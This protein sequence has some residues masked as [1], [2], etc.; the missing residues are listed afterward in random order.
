M[1]AGDV[2]FT[3]SM[4][5]GGYG[6]PLRR[7][8]ELV[9]RDVE[10][11]LVSREWARR[12]YGVVFVEGSL[13]VDGQATAACRR[14]LVDER[15]RA[16]GAEAVG[17]P[18]AWEPEREGVRLSELLFYDFS[19]EDPTLR[20][21]CGHVLGPAT[22]PYKSLA[23]SARYPVQRIGPHVNP[24]DIGRGRFELRE[25]YCPGCFTLLETEIARPGDPVLDDAALSLAWV[26]GRV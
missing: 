25:F 13:E 11:S 8:P 7:D 22:E 6:D 18:Q 15:R 9:S 24:H 5:G 12:T 19:G 4:G 21:L 20:C 2:Y 16:A 17:T 3:M 23:A 14:E 1:R 26:E 10:R